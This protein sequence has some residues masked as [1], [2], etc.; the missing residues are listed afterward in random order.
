MV[1]LATKWQGVAHLWAESSLRA[2][3]VNAGNRSVVGH[4]R[5]LLIFSTSVHSSAFANTVHIRI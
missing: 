2:R 3:I 4:R 1:T 5:G